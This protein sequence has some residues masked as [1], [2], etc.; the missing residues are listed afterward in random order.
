MHYERGIIYEKQGDT[1]TA[2]REYQMALVDDKNYKEP[3]AAL[4]RLGG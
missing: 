4:A 3:Q 1:A 2:K